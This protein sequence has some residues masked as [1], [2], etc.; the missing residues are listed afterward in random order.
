MS[1]FL[2]N[3]LQQVK[4]GGSAIELE[5]DAKV[6]KGLPATS[7]DHASNIAADVTQSSAPL[8]TLKEKSV[9]E[10]LQKALTENIPA[11]GV[12]TEEV[13]TILSQLSDHSNEHYKHPC[14]FVQA[15]QRQGFTV[16]IPNYTKK[17]GAT[18][19]NIV[20]DNGLF[21]TTDIR[22]V[23][24]LR[25]A[26]SR[27]G[28]IGPHI[29]EITVEHYNNILALGSA[30]N[31]LRGVSGVVSTTDSM[32]ATGG[33]SAQELQNDLEAKERELAAMK[34]KIEAIEANSGGTAAQENAK[35]IFGNPNAK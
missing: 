24:A 6:D 22:L 16:M 19:T 17:E 13:K 11:A 10:G 12:L 15:G 34:A 7:V 14:H 33:K 35:N 26:I 9:A 20:F 23:N 29:K 1:T 31:K 4:Q 32:P 21:I 3:Q 8:H 18:S 25:L 5:N 30:A 27:K 28:G 2:K